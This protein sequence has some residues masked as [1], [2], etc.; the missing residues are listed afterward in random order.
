MSTIV[1]VDEEPALV[2]ILGMVLEGDGHEV[3]RATT[4]ASA[5]RLIAHARPQVIVCSDVA[6]ISLVRARVELADVMIVLLV[7]DLG[8]SSIAPAV[9][10]IAKPV[11]LSELLGLVRQG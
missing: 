10:V 8:I 5:L 9:H 6:L 7:D 11:I 3:R 2:E 4:R 1:L